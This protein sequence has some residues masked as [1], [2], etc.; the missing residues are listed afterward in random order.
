MTPEQIAALKAERQAIIDAQNGGG[1]IDRGAPVNGPSPP[2]LAETAVQGVKDTA[3]FL[4]TGAKV[5]GEAGVDLGLMAAE[6]AKEHPEKIA[7][8]LAEEGA[9]ALATRGFSA[10]ANARHIPK[11]GKMVGG[12]IAASSAAAGGS[13]VS[14]TFDPSEDPFGRALETALFAA[15]GDVAGEVGSGVAKRMVGNRSEDAAALAA[16]QAEHKVGL[17]VQDTLEPSG[18]TAVMDQLDFL[19]GG[20]RLANKRAKMGQLLE[21]DLDSIVDGLEAAGADTHQV[22]TF[23]REAL[24]NQEA[25]FRSMGGARYDRVLRQVGDAPVEMDGLIAS[26][27]DA[28][29][30]WGDRK[31]LGKIA[32]DDATKALSM[33][34]A[35]A[36]RTALKK[37]LN[38]GRR[39]ATP[40]P[41]HEQVELQNAVDALTGQM[42]AT[43]ESVS[44]RVAEGLRQA[45][46][47]WAQGKEVFGATQVQKLLG[48][49]TTGNQ[50]YSTVMAN[51]G[52]VDH[53]RQIKRALYDEN[54]LGANLGLDAATLAARREASDKAMNEVRGRFLRDVLRQTEEQTGKTTA[55]VRLNHLNRFEKSG[56]LQ[57]M[58]GGKKNE[59]DN[60]RRTLRALRQVERKYRTG[61]LGT[62][63]RGTRVLMGGGGLAAGGFSGATLAAG[64][65]SA[66]L[67]RLTT[68]RMFANVLTGLAESKPGTKQAA[69]FMARMTRMI[70]YQKEQEAKQEQDQ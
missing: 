26:H 67:A 12:A 44:P 62:I 9:T 4:G 40:M 64:L 3:N 15:G 11:I 68:S 28:L 35:Q 45:D 19:P 21:G 2:T 58:F 27:R 52:D 13:L 17:P 5:I 39:A 23:L 53:L 54:Y 1:G 8:F 37:E 29:T 18:M 31:I 57:E 61:H 24:G 69:K 38:Q 33:A 10:L 41:H 6:Y 46:Q 25:A 70:D 50:V 65:G 16:K 43:A 48:R 51:G 30:Q 66:S 47:F 34:D 49:E 32:G 60:F 56:F 59:I 14:E 20:G 55:N 22:G 7:R 63:T 42:E 36:L